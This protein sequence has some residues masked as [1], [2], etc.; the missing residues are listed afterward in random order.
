MI[1]FIAYKDDPPWLFDVFSSDI[2]V[3]IQMSE[4]VPSISVRWTCIKLIPW[5]NGTPNGN[6]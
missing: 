2:S 3:I 4:E 6:D 1:D 5:P